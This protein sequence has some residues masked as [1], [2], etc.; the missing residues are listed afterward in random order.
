VRQIVS[1]ALSLLR[2][3]STK[4]P[5]QR[6]ELLQ[7]LHYLDHSF[8][9]NPLDSS[10]PPPIPSHPLVHRPVSHLLLTAPFDCKSH[11]PPP[12][13]A[14]KRL[15]DSVPVSQPKI[16]N[17][18]A[19]VTPEVR[20]APA[21]LD[22]STLPTRSTPLARSYPLSSGPSKAVEAAEAAEADEA[23]AAAEHDEM[24]RAIGLSLDSYMTP[25]EKGQEGMYYKPEVPRLTTSRP[26]ARGTSHE[27]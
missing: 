2:R 21:A 15:S 7:G 1:I 8:A 12:W 4:T 16:T 14:A 24:A 19:A 13:P 17:M 3:P 9:H 18:F 11:R 23:D 5:R 10:H 25:R 26:L 27:A 6:R 22:R 20:A